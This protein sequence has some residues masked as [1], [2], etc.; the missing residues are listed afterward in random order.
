MRGFRVSQNLLTVIILFIIFGIGFSLRAVF[1][2]DLIFKGDWV[3]FSSI[4][5]YY[6]MRLVDN[7]V[8]NFPSIIEWDYYHLFPR[9]I[10]LSQTPHFFSWLLAAIIWVIG[11]GSPSPHLINVIGVYYPVML[12]V[13]TIIPVY[14]IGK[15]L[16]N[17]WAG[18]IAAGLLM[19]MPGEYIGRSIL[20]FT[21]YHVA[22]T[23]FT[24]TLIMFFLFAI[25]TSRD[26]GLGLDHLK[27]RNWAVI[28]RPLVYSALAGLFLAIYLLTWAG[29]LLFVFIITLY[30]VIQS[31]VDHLR[32]HSTDYLG[33]TGFFAFGVALIIS[34]G[35]LPGGGFYR[36]SLIA[37]PVIPLLLLAVSRFLAGRKMKPGYYPMALLGLGVLGTVIFLVAAPALLRTILS[38]FSIFIPRGGLTTLEMGPLLSPRGN[39]TLTIA[40]GN[41]TFGFFLSLGYLLY[42]L[43]YKDLYK[44][45][46]DSGEN[47][48]LVW[49]ILILLATLAQRR[50]AYY[51]AVN[52][53]LIS[54]YVSW[55]L[56]WYAGL[57]RLVARR[58]QISRIPSRKKNR[59]KNVWKTDTGIGIYHVN[60]VLAVLVVFFFVFAPNVWLGGKSLDVAKNVQFAPPDS[61]Y[62]ALYWMRDNTPEPFGDA[63]FYYRHYEDGKYEYPES[64]YGVLTWWDYGYWVTRIAH[65]VPNANPSQPPGPI[66]D[67]ANFFLS[68]D[69]ASAQGIIEKL[70]S[71]YI[72]IDDQ[73]FGS[74]YWAIA[75]WSGQEGTKF[76]EVYY[77]PQEGRLIPA[78][79]FYPEYYQSLVV[80]LY[81]FDGEAVTDISPVV[82]TYEEVVQNNGETIKR[83]TDGKQFDTYEEA[84][85]YL[86]EHDSPNVRLVGGNPFVSPVPLEAL[87][88]YRL[89]F[90]SPTGT[91]KPEVGFVPGVKVFE[92]IP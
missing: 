34:F 67:T 62:E 30:L 47:L 52:V 90:S 26:R 39:F 79:L 28:T 2:H 6:H 5:A 82:I 21:D 83:V 84:L 71:S 20:G 55:Q 33:F 77:L 18:V 7:I 17:R 89:A 40:F 86:Q 65:R 4:D 60:T 57:R 23:L 61:W 32:G 35:S 54:G 51:F 16:F 69:E 50:F 76:F 13:L 81:G 29:A 41:F 45:R 25:K 74:K 72:V 12:A 78:N 85:T 68:Q 24:T 53:A 14:F 19:V 64:A 31:I 58:A 8:H 73:T 1:P 48:L 42:L 88:H 59:E 22:E 44:R 63:E 37:A 36:L 66:I 38:Q 49:S 10:N 27:Q 87:E 9:P 91:M 92:Y 80:R 56:I 43:C 75:D 3:K 15:L 46:W 70:D 11:F